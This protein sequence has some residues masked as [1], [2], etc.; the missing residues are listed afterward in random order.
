MSTPFADDSLL[1]Q[2]V[3]ET[4]VSPH[5]RGTVLRSERAD[6]ERRA[7][8]A[9]QVTSDL[10]SA[11]EGLNGILRSNYFG[12]CREGEGVFDGLTRAT[13][14]LSSDLTRGVYRASALGERC[15]AAATSIEQ[16]DMEGAADFAT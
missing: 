5:G 13:A 15:R 6:W 16:V 11:L 12:D 7:A 8:V 3:P 1:P 4:P 9:E 2:A 10:T 14:Q